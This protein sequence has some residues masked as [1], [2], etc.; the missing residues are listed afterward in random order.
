[1]RILCR[2]H[3][4]IALNMKRHIGKTAK[5]TNNVPKK[6]ARICTT[7]MD[8][9]VQ[10][11]KSEQETNIKESQTP[12]RLGS[13]FYNQDCISLAKALLGKILVRLVDGVRITGRIV[14][15]EAYLG[16]KDSACHSYK[17]RKTHRNQA[18]FMMP[19]SLY[20]YIIYGMYHCMNIS[21]KGLY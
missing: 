6:C 3:R 17:R 10:S 4:N 15:T 7:V 1:M 20:V 16:V 11:D 8:A 13:N 14:E 2:M 9:T 19:G 21:C 18:M 12:L 5:E